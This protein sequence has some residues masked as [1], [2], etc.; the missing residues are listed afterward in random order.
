MSEIILAI[1]IMCR[2]E[3]TM[4]M[5]VVRIQQLQ[6]KCVAE[7]IECHGKHQKSK[8]PIVFPGCIWSKK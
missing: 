3:G 4:N 2:A 1:A 7:I 6:R 8:T 5:S